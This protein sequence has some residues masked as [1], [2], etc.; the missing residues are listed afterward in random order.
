MNKMSSAWIGVK[1]NMF[2]EKYSFIIWME[3][4]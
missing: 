4:R 3:P 1:K 2:K